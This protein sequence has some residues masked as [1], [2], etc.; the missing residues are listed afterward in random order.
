MRKAEADSN[1]TFI[2]QPPQAELL[3]H[4]AKACVARSYLSWFETTGLSLLEAGAMGCLGGMAT[5]SYVR[6][7]FWRLGRVL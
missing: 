3:Q 5:A 6:G 1:I 2:D 4:Y 7:L